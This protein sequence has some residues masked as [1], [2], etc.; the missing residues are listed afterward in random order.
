L[1]LR[2]V[3]ASEAVFGDVAE[4]FMPPCQRVHVMTVMV[5]MAAGIQT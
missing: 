2:S 1:S 5:Y 4:E 3:S